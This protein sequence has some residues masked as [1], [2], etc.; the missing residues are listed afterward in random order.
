MREGTNT[1]TISPVC[2]EWHGWAKENFMW[3]DVIARVLEKPNPA[4][5]KLAKTFREA[6]MMVSRDSSLGMVLDR[7]G[8][9]TY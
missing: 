4:C 2:K 3:E 1:R 5:K 7:Y 6:T 8:I 9:L